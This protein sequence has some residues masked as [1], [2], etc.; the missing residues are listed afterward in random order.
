M[1]DERMPHSSKKLPTTSIRRVIY[2]V[3]PLF[4]LILCLALINFFPLLVGDSTAS[5]VSEGGSLQTET[6]TETV[7]KASE[8]AATAVPPTPTLQPAPTPTNPLPPNAAI[9]LLGPPDDS[10]FLLD[11]ANN[12]VSFYW[13]WPQTLSEDQRLVLYIRVGEQDTPLGALEEPNMGNAY[14]WQEDMTAFMDTAV[15]I[16]WLVKLQTVSDPQL[17]LA[18]SEART[19]RLSP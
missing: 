16:Q 17:V 9:S 7:T 5:P 8:A 2:I 14:R 10:L 15:P 3:T 18:E 11:S 4:L 6:E 19:L 12:V 1:G 13:A